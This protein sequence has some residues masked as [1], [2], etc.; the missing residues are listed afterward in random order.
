MRTRIALVVVALLLVAAGSAFYVLAYTQTGIELAAAQLSR[1]KTVGI[2][3]DGVS[4]RLTGPLR[5]ARFELDH[6]RVHL[7]VED[8]VIDLHLRWLA[9]QTIDIT[10][11]TAARSVVELK[12]APDEPE[13]TTPLRFLP[14]F[15]SIAVDR[16]DLAAVTLTLQNGQTFAI[17][18]VEAAAQL[19]ASRLRVTELAIDSALADVGGTV[20]LTA[21]RPVGLDIDVRG[22]VPD[23]ER[24]DLALSATARGSADTLQIETDLTAPAAAHVSAT[25]TRPEDAWQIDGKVTSTTFALAPW[26]PSSETT[27]QAVALDFSARPDGIRVNG[28]LAVPELD[29]AP[30]LVDASGRYADRTLAIAAARIT[31]PGSA[32]RIDLAGEARFAGGPPALS[33]TTTWQS[34]QWPLSATSPAVRSP[35]GR[36]TVSG[37]SPY[38]FTANAAIV[39]PR[40]PAATATV[41][42]SVS[43]DALQIASYQLDLLDGNVSGAGSLALAAPQRWTLSATGQ[44]VNP[45]S[46]NAQFPGRIDFSATATGSGLTA[47]AD[48]RLAVARLRGTLRGQPLNG[49][50]SIARSASGWQLVETALALGNA[51]LSVTGMVSEAVNLRWSLNATSLASLWP[52]AS[53]RVQFSGSA[54]GPLRLP[55]VVADIEATSLALGDWSVGSLSADIDVD[56]A[57]TTDSAVRIDAGALR[58]GPVQAD[59]LRITGNGNPGAHTLRA[60]LASR[61]ARGKLATAELEVSGSYANEVWTGQIASGRLLDADGTQPL[62]LAKPAQALFSRERIEV[63]ELCLYLLDS[64]V[65]GSGQWRRQGPWRIAAT[66]DDIPLDILREILADQPQ[67]L[68]KMDLDVTAEGS[69]T[70]PWRGDASIVLT[71]GGIVYRLASEDAKS[72]E[73]VQLGSG[74][75]DIRADATSLS[76]AVGLSGTAESFIAANATLTRV[77]GVDLGRSPLTGRIRGRMGD[78]NLLPVL[79]AEID[80]AAGALVADVTLS[81][82]VDA[83]QLDG[84]IELNRGALDLYRLNLALREMEVQLNLAANRLQFTGNGRAGDGTWNLGGTLNWQD[85]RPVGT[86]QLKGDHLLVADLPEYRVVASPDLTFKIDP[87]SIRAEGE[88][89]IPSARIQPRDLTGAVQISADSRLLADEPVTSAGRYEVSSG[90]RVRLGDDVQL[91]TFGLQGKLGGSVNTLTRTGL[92]AIGRGELTV[93]NG[94]YEAY[95]QKLDISRGRLLFDGTPLDDPGLDIQAE[96]RIET[97]KVGLNVRGTLRE[98]R[99]GF[100]SEPSMSQTQILSYLLVGKPLDDLQNRDTAA[101]GSARDSLALQGGGILAAQLGRRLGLEE[102]GVQTQGANQTALVLG[103]FLSPRLFVSY[104]IS[105]TESIN[106]LKLR[107]TITDRWV[108]KTEAGEHQSADVE[109]IIERP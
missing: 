36:L 101:V 34:L 91:D 52:E 100:Y 12:P 6:K 28:Q 105:L 45:A 21:A 66:G 88:V 82:R 78:A 44:D 107:Y 55:H 93:A 26:V 22:V 25:L 86:L 87:H 40:L 32:L 41:T 90:I 99:F 95:G 50:G 38:Q 53:G 20:L 65:C 18:R 108:L 49:S 47:N 10:S 29:R 80:D 3:V 92:I 58:R 75:A 35:A 89:L 62:R 30:L 13:P 17:D 74:R 83:P 7:V 109:F 2:R 59:S 23:G 81:G 42:G 8:I 67:Y 9:L 54:V 76:V 15:L 71:G 102:V 98:P 14:G 104:G 5:I 84:R 73:T 68:G 56:P 94:K 70:M 39:T 51:R 106:T 24:P 11:A 64:S 48:F 16:I 61:A 19:N 33:M 27:F 85:G 97:T 60:Q 43:P 1:L 57:G 69:P 37:A 63:G 77:P 46:L 4:G 31:Q 79:V 96:R 72:T 103:K